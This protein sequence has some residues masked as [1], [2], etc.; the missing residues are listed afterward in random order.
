MAQ[1]GQYQ[2]G[3]FASPVN[4]GPLDA[5]VV[6]GNDNALVGVHDNHDN[7]PTIHVQSF[8]FA[9]LPSASTLGRFLIASDT[10]RAYFDTGSALAELAYFSKAG[11]TLTGPITAPGVNRLTGSGGA[12]GTVAAWRFGDTNSA[13]SRDWS[14]SNG[15]GAGAADIGVLD[16]C[17]SAAASGD[18]L[19]NTGTKILRLTSGGV[20]VVGSITGTSSLGIAGALTGA[21]TGAFSSNVSVGG[22]FGVTGQ[23]TLNATQF[24]GAANSVVFGSQ[25]LGSNIIP[26]TTATYDLGSS[27]NRWQ[28]LFAS[29]QINT[30]GSVVVG[31][32]LTVTGIATMAAISGTTITASSG[33][34][35]TLMTAAQTNI[36]SLGTLTSVAVTNAATV[37]KLKGGGGT[38][39]LTGIPSGW[40]GSISGTDAGGV[41]TLVANGTNYTAGTSIATVTFTSTYGT[42]PS[43]T[44][45]TAG[46]SGNAQCGTLPTAT[47]F[48]AQLDQSVIGG[49]GATF[50]ILYQVVG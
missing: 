25:V 46:I 17:I 18:P 24:S 14:I 9:S 34:T 28:D 40:S 49:G 11:G 36:T 15:Y 47:V 5:T 44:L 16:F 8:P 42:A 27:G 1:V 26:G 32:T 6:R 38:P 3:S 4:G 22:T 43:V 35:G 45:S 31:T 39:V 30:T 37:G 29:G 33:L 10:Q 2:I 48:H 19:A 7:D 13:S 23:T 12:A 20:A 50:Y 21:T 41:I